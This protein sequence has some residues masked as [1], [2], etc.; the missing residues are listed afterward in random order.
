MSAKSL[1]FARRIYIPR[2][3]GSAAGFSAV[4]SAL[5][6]IPTPAWL[7]LLLVL[8]AF[9]W[10]H[11][12]FQLSRRVSVSYVVERRNLVIDAALGGVWVAAMHFNT[13]PSTMLISM[14]CMNSMAVGGPRLLSVCLGALGA[15]LLAFTAILQPGFAPATTHLQVY[16]CLPMLGIYPLA[17]G[18]SAYRLAA[19]LA[20]HKR[21]LRDFSRT[22]SL[23]GLLNQGAWRAALDDEYALNSRTGDCS[24]LALIDIDHFKA[25]NDG[26]GHLTGD[27]VI[28]VFGT[29]KRSTDIAGR[30]GGDEFGLILRDSDES[31]AEKLLTRMQQHLREIFTTRVDLPA[32]SLS[33]GMAK[34][35]PQHDS[36]EAWIRTSDQALYK[37][38]R[39]GRNRIVSSGS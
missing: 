4:A 21:A 31:Q 36:V 15:A 1:S 32:V 9:V 3:L 19:K 30:I 12:A 2:V 27:E 34:F 33:I 37:A 13:L 23:T 8:H 6:A 22:D 5:Y 24:T 18:A 29:V 11:V 10:P 7:W 39:E 14:L 35:E 26:Y 17:V 28:K 38:K 16:A 25:I 20:E